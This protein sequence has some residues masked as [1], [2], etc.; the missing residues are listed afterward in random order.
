MVAL[1]EGFMRAST[2]AFG[3]D[4]F[5]TNDPP[6]MKQKLRFFDFAAFATCFGATV[7]LMLVVWIQSFKGWNLGLA[8]C[9]LFILSGLLVGIT[10]SP[11][12]RYRLP[13]GSPL[14]R[15]FQVYI[16]A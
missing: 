3:S 11:F 1:G 14:T 16:C 5:D 8:V 9:A 10:G 6:Q 13:G 7:G 4:Q 2:P 12:Y 15:I